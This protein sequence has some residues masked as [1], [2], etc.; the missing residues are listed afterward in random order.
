MIDLDPYVGKLVCVQM[1]D[2]CFVLQADKNGEPTITAINQ[3]GRVV[4]VQMPMVV[5]RVVRVGTGFGVQYTD[6]NGSEM[7][8]AINTDAVIEA[9]VVV[10]IKEEVLCANVREASRLVGLG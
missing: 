4:P 3:E 6:Q 8:V 10:R 5:G 7:E 2:S 9:G 1:R